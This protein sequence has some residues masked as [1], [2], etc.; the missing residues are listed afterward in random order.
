VHVLTHLRRRRVPYWLTASTAALLVALAVGRLSAAAAAERDRWGT[1]RPA[2]VVTSVVRAGDRLAGHVTT[3]SVPVALL[4]RRAL[5]TLPPDAVAAVELAPG[6]IVLAHRLTGRSTVAARMPA[7]T[8]AVAVPSAGGL[9]L[10][11]GDRV[12]VLATFDTGD[13]AS[14]PTLAV[15]HDALV[16]AVGEEAATVAVS[17][18]AAP[19]VAYA[20]A[21]GTITLVLSG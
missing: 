18:S 10:E 19:R 1:T 13:T 4:P 2:V 3:R 14:E 12:D 7:G 6:E 5:A 17:Q 9:P 16:L 15:A 21:V 20:L 11:V 8:R